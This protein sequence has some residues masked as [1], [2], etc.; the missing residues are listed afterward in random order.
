VRCKLAAVKVGTALAAVAA[1]AALAPAT[2]AAA[3][4][5]ASPSGAG[6]ACTQAAPCDFKM[7]VEGALDGDEVIVEPGVHSVGLPAEVLLDTGAVVHGVDGQPRPTIVSAAPTALRVT[8]PGAQL[9]W[10]GVMHTGASDALVLEAGLGERL[11]VSSTGSA[12]ACRVDDAALQDSVCWATG[13]GGDAAG[14]VAQTPSV[15]ERTKLM[16][17]TA[18]AA[19]AGSAGLRVESEPSGWAELVALN[20]IARG[21]VDTEIVSTPTS[22]S[23]AIIDF[24]NFA[25]Q[26]STG[27]NSFASPPGQ[28]RNQ[29]GGARFVDAANGDFHQDPDSPTIDWGTLDIDGDADIDGEPRLQGFGIDIGA[30]EH[31]V[32]PQPP[33]SNPPDT[34]ILRFPKRRSESRKASFKFG[35]T[36]PVGAIFMCSVDGKPFK[37]CASPKKLRVKRGRRHRFAVFSVDEAG[38]VDPSPDAYAWK[39]T[40][41]E[42][43][44]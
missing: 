10:L 39:V 19:G 12:L 24:S 33:D 18:V 30:D 40:R 7:A 3:Q 14:M 22:I 42:R 21:A 31:F 6:M 28:S 44:D 26:S 35:T 29:V 20:V 2:A 16:N 25:T 9:R 41:K 5:H 8:H 15:T 34:R 36:E 1:T 27:P 32:G 13:A 4:R 43:D 37:P 38:N 23:T 17:V 11:Y